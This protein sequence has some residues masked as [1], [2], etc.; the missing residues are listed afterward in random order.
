MDRFHFSSHPYDG[1]AYEIMHVIYKI[2]ERV[3]EGAQSNGTLHNCHSTAQFTKCHDHQ[4][5]Q[6]HSSIGR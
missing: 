6:I 5:D 4:H 3:L 1:M 2:S